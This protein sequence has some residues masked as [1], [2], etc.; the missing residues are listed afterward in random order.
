MISTR[1]SDI[2]KDI[3]DQVVSSIK[4]SP[5]KI[6]IQLDESTDVSNCSQLIVMG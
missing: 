4:A 3:L 5:V 1:I 6:P 2:S